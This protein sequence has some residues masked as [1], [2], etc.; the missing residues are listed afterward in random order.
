[1]HVGYLAHARSTSAGTRMYG[2]C[3]DG[4]VFIYMQL[5]EGQTLEDAWDTLAQTE[6]ASIFHALRQMVQS[7][8]SLR[9]ASRDS[10]VGEL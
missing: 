9:Q 5:I 3:R 8:W 4:E 7:L 1:M 2:W 6:C 10:F